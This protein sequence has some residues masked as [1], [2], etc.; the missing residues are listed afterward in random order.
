MPYFYRAFLIATVLVAN[1]SF[2]KSV[3]SIQIGKHKIQW[4]QS[5]IRRL[6]G[7]TKVKLSSDPTYGSRVRSFEAIRASKLFGKVA[8]QR[9]LARMIREGSTLEFYCR[10][11]FSANLPIS[12]VLNRNDKTAV[13]YIAVEPPNKKWPRLKTGLTAGPFYLIWKNAS[14]S[15]IG[16]EEWPY[17]LSGFIV[18]PPIHRRFPK[19]VPHTRNEKVLAGFHLFEKNCFTCHTMNGEGD[20][21]LGPDLNLPMNPTQYFRA[22]MIRRLIRNPQNLRQWPES[23][24]SSFPSNVLSDK[25]IDHIIDYLKFISRHK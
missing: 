25:D 1:I 7:F 20:S 11:G 22:G 14:R 13:A 8:S 4:R 15:Q 12:L 19:I 21:H 18:K 17:Q 23:K 5:E 2:A 16:P 3:L 6:P 9:E 24:M 10:D